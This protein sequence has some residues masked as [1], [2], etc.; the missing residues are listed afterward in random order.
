MDKLQLHQ[1]SSYAHY[2]HNRITW[3]L[4]AIAAITAMPL[5]RV[6]NS[7]Y[8]RQTSVH[9]PICGFVQYSDTP[10]RHKSGDELFDREETDARK[11]CFDLEMEQTQTLPRRLY[12]ICRCAGGETWEPD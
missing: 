9:L 10:G 2:N 11:L 8:I 6:R 4:R 7:T 12:K 5:Y 1:H 3:G